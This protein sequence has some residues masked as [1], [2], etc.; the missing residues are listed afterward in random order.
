MGNYTYVGI[1]IGKLEI[2]CSLPER[3]PFIL[4]NDSIGI[5]A[6]L[7]RART[8]D[9]PGNLCFVMESTSVYSSR[10]AEAILELADTWVVIVPPACVNGFKQAGLVR[11]KNDFVDAVAIREFAEVK[12]PRP[13][14]P[15]AQAQRRL[16]NLQVVMGNLVNAGA[17]LK[18]IREKLLNEHHHDD[19]ALDSTN[20]M[21][22]Q[23]DTELTNLQAET[24]KV[25]ASD[26]VMA[27]DSANIMSIPGIGPKVRNVMM[28]VIY[29][30]L[31]NLPQRKLLSYCGMSPRE[32]ISGKHKGRTIMSKAGDA[33]VRSVLYMA[34]LVTIK[35]SGLMHDYYQGQVASG[36]PG[37]VAIVN[38]MRRLLY[39]IQGVVKANSPFDMEVFLQ[40][41]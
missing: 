11:T 7:K 28:S 40:R 34:A 32:H 33:R 10:T 4:S 12:H 1:D 15:P 19:I 36:K 35:K 26:E 3:K 13:W 14:L 31:R 8:I 37:K 30:Q 17:R 2:C 21:I 27:T 6:L 18:N 5:K 38:V 20:R 23:I 9:S 29:E 25:I 41:G 24:D 39:I 22:S 16:R